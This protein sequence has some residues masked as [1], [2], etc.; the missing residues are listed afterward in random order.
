[1]NSTKDILIVCLNKPVNKNF[2]LKINDYSELAEHLDTDG[3]NIVDIEIFLE[4][5]RQDRTNNIVGFLYT[6]ILGLYIEEKTYKLFAYIL[7]SFEVRLGYFHLIYRLDPYFRIRLKHLLLKNTHM[8]LDR[9]FNYWY[10]Q[11]THFSY[12]LENENLAVVKTIVDRFL[13]EHDVLEQFYNTDIPDDI[14]NIILDY[15][16]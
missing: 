10:K 8:F 14:T 2:H 5:L 15:S 11:S 4:E 12:R 6:L 1:M 16:V 9:N 3:Y 13:F 7:N